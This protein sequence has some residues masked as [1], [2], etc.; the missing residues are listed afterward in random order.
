MKPALCLSVS[1]LLLLPWSGHSQQ[2]LLA[3][4]DLTQIRL[5]GLQL[6]MSQNLTRNLLQQRYNTE[7]NAQFVRAGVQC[8]KRQCTATAVGAD[9][10]EILQTQFNAKGELN[11]IILQRRNKGGSSPEECLAQA[12]LQVEQLRQQYSPDN[13]QRRFRQHSVGFML[14]KTGHPDPAENSLY[15]F[16]A[17]IKCDPL[18]KGEAQTEYELRDSSL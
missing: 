11:W 10:Q 12:E 1:L 3:E 7:A 17:L 18:A 5:E 2:S 4:A 14:N 9:L 13:A 6:G 8:D 16:R 15:G